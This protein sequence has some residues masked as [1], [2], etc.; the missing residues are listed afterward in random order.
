MQQSLVHVRAHAH[1]WHHLV[2]EFLLVLGVF[3][4]V[5]IPSTS[6]AMR[7]QERGLYMN[8]AEAGDRTFYTLGFRYMSPDPVGSVELLF[9]NDP[10]PYNPCVI[11]QDFSASSATLGQ[12]VGETGF[13][14]AERSQNRILLTRA[15]VPP[16][17]SKS[18]Y[19]LENMLNPTD[20]TQAFSI[21]IKTFT[22][23]NGTGPQ[24]DFGS[25]RGQISRSIMLATQVP[26]M[27]I[28]CLAEQVDYHC[29][30]TNKVHYQNMGQ[31]SANNTL[32]AQSQMAVG[33]NASGGFAIIAQGRPL[34]AG[35]NVIQALRQPTESQPGVD[36]FGINLVANNAPMI[37]KDPEGE[38]KN[39][40]TMAG[41]GEPNK[42]KFVSGDVV[43]YSPN[44]SLMKKFTVSYI[45]NVNPNL[46]A[47][48]YSTTVNYIATG[49]F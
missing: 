41:Y 20:S 31:L 27:L 35:T 25:V 46:R 14:I 10:I 3:M 23:T 17:S 37:G 32:T 18:S 11:P 12:Q 19:T 9:C 8:S 21:R 34:S 48:V 39:A 40:V 2:A 1:S 49:R 22:S 26:P 28:F 45:V 38:W 15:S 29:A 24:V 5:A 36:Q 44:V 13:V 4:F 33:T 47:G 30:G 7:L 42:Y 6:A 16:M 43:A